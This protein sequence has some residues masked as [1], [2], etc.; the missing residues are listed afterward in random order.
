MIWPKW[1][2][3]IRASIVYDSGY[4]NTAQANA[5]LESD[6]VVGNVVLVAPELL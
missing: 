1:R 3:D 4:G 5:L 2:L 6:V